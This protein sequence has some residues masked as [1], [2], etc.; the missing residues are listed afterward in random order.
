MLSSSK[1]RSEKTGQIANRLI[2]SDLVILD[3]LSHLPFSASGSAAVHQQ[4][5]TTPAIAGAILLSYR[6]HKG[7]VV[8]IPMF[9]LQ[10]RVDR[11]YWSIKV[12]T[13]MKDVF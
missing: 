4:C 2:H 10:N 11:F 9:G 3:G 12:M 8:E 5:L 1:R 13:G 7:S 6:Q